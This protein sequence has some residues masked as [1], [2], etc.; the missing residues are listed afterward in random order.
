VYITATVFNEGGS[1]GSQDMPLLIN[2]QFEQSVP[3]GVAAGTGQ[4]IAFTVYKTEAREYQVTIG[5]AT[6]TFYIMQEATQQ[7]Q[8][9]GLLAGGELDT[10]GI[11]AIVCIGVIIIAGIVLVFLFA[12]RP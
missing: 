6:G 8:K 1:W 10:G 3:V 12:R 7:P 2:G 4:T 11:I 9:A 5:D